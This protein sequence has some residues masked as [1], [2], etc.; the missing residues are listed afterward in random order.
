MYRYFIKY[1]DYISNI[2]RDN[3]DLSELSFSIKTKLKKD[4]YSIESI[5]FYKDIIKDTINYTKR[6]KKS[7]LLI[8]IKEKDLNLYNPLSIRKFEHKKDNLYKKVTYKKDVLKLINY[9]AFIDMSVNEINRGNI[10]IAEPCINDNK[11]IYLNTNINSIFKKKNIQE[12]R[13]E[14]ISKKIGCDIYFFTED[15][16][17]LEKYDNDITEV[18]EIDC[19]KYII[20]K[21]KLYIIDSIKNSDLIGFSGSNYLYLDLITQDSIP[22]YIIEKNDKYIITLDDINYGKKGYI[23][24]NPQ[25][26]KLLNNKEMIPLLKFINR[27]EL[28]NETYKKYSIDIYGKESNTLKYKRV[29]KRD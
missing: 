9:D 21:Q 7:S 20:I 2:S 23:I 12:L 17:L 11:Y 15:E 19:N 4:L 28:D 24:T 16:Y 8:E 1:E 13:I 29:N 5:I 6:N 3:L 22:I 26:N 10:V 18:K 14:L 27:Y 25:L